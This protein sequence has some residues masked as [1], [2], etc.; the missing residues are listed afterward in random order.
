MTTTQGAKGSA[1]RPADEGG[2][3]VVGV[4]LAPL[5]DDKDQA[6]EGAQG[7]KGGDD[8]RDVGEGDEQAVDGPHPGADGDAQQ[9]TQVDVEIGVIAEDH[10]DH[11]P[12]KTER[13]AN[14]DVDAAGDDDHHLAHGHH[15]EERDP[16]Q[17]AADVDGLKEARFDGGCQGNDQDE[18][19]DDASFAEARHADDNVTGTLS[20]GGT[21]N[22]CHAFS[23]P[24][25]G[26]AR[27]RRP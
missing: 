3:H 8:G 21:G 20:L 27:W 19:D 9:G 16:E 12:G 11:D 6:A 13:G 25:G 23:M 26:S 10:A 7:A 17:D 2:G 15:G 18:K 22:D 4:D 24:P 5:A 1:L 14:R